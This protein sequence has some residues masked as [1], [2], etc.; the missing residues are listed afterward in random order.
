MS[1][2]IL[3]VKSVSSVITDHHQSRKSRRRLPVRPN[4]N[5]DGAARPQ[6][7]RRWLRSTEGTF[8]LALFLFWRLI[9]R[10]RTT[11]LWGQVVRSLRLIVQTDTS[12]QQWSHLRDS[13]PWFTLR[14]WAV[15]FFFIKR[16][17]Y[18]P[19]HSLHYF[20]STCSLSHGWWANLNAPKCHR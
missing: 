2:I 7:A 16:L 17:L 3:S 4:L 6:R 8:C 12:C 10:T 5:A 11:C 13:R 19:R 9:W 15:W 18:S 14:I 20:W 1:W